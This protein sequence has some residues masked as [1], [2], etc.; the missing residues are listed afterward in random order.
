M[1]PLTHD[2]CMHRE[3]LQG[4]GVRSCFPPVAS[5][6]LAYHSPGSVGLRWGVPHRSERCD[7]HVA[8]SNLARQPTQLAGS[9]LVEALLPHT[10]HAL[11]YWAVCKSMRERFRANHRLVFALRWWNPDSLVVGLGDDPPMVLPWL[12]RSELIMCSRPV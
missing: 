5:H 8:A 7:F 1:D 9:I 2:A 10:T 4:V 3:P 12:C 11:H 6:Y